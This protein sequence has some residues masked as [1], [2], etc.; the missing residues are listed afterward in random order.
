MKRSIW[1]KVRK[2]FFEEDCSSKI[3]QVIAIIMNEDFWW[4]T[5]SRENQ[6]F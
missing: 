1:H 4:V 5:F 6:K 2:I 3:A